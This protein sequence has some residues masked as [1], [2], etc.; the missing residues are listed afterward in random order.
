MAVLCAALALLSSSQTIRTIFGCVFLA[1][2]AYGVFSTIK[3]H[4]NL[5]AKLQRGSGPQ[6]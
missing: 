4:E 2:F 5:R 3:V 6:R 1:V